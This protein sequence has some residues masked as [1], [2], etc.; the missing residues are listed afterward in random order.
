MSLCEAE[1]EMASTMFAISNRTSLEDAA[2]YGRAW[3]IRAVLK[4]GHAPVGE[5]EV[6]D[7]IAEPGN[8]MRM[9]IVQ[10]QVLRRKNN[11]S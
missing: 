8:P 9:V 4:D 5:P 6:L 1:T 11:G 10:G 3:W 7:A 2:R